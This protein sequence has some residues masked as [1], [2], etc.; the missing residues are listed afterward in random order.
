MVV[1]VVVFGGIQYPS[2]IVPHRTGGQEPNIQA[3]VQISSHGIP[4]HP[5]YNKIII[6]LPM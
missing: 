3:A 2:A 4:A 6:K 1:G 5:F